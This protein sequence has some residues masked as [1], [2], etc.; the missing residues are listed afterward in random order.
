[1]KEIEVVA[2]ILKDT[3]GRILA[4]E[5]GKGTWKGY[6]EFPGGKVEKEETSEE[7]LKRELFEEL[8]ITVGDFQF[9][10]TISYQYPEFHLTM[11]CFFCKIVEGEIT[12]NEHSQMRW[13]YPDEL[14]S[15]DWLPADYQIFPLIRHPKSL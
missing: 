10:T 5:R 9:L 1:M 3:E 8:G 12:L 13:L 14:E 6:W 7:A 11:H 15:V 2:G 4:V